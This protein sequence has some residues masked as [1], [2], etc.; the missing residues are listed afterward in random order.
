MNR[1]YCYFEKLRL[2]IRENAGQQNTSCIHLWSRL[3]K[4]QWIIDQ[5]VHFS[6]I[7]YLFTSNILSGC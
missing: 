5:F 3:N 2:K 7:N 1:K 6:S 4:I